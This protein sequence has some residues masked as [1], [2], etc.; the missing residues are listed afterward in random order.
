[1]ARYDSAE[2]GRQPKCLEGTRVSAQD[3]ILSWVKD[4]S[5]SHIFWLTG[6]AGT[7]KSTLARTLLETFL[8]KKQLAAGYFFK[9]GHQG[10]NGTAQFFSTLA[11]QLVEVLPEYKERLRKSLNDTTSEALK[12]KSLRRQ[13]EILFLEP[14]KELQPEES[15]RFSRVIIVDALDECDVQEDICEILQLFSELQ[16]IELFRLC[17]LLTSRGARLIDDAFRTL[18]DEQIPY[19]GLRLHE[20]HAEETKADISAYLHKRFLGMT[21]TS[22]MDRREWPAPAQM[23]RLLKLATFPSPLFIYAS[24]LCRFVEDRGRGRTPRTQLN[25]WL[26]RSDR[27]ISQLGSMYL[28][29]LEEVFQL[30]PEEECDFTSGALLQGHTILSAVILLASPISTLALANLLEMPADSV[31]SW[32]QDLQAVLNTSP[33][34]ERPLELLH[35][36]FGDFLLDSENPTAGK[37]RVDSAETHSMLLS[38]CIRRMTHNGL[39]RDICDLQQ[40]G[41]YAADVEED[42]I[43]ESIPHDLEYASLYWVE[44]FDQSSSI[45][46][47]AADVYSFLREHLLHWLEALSLLRKTV[48]AISCIRR[49]LNRFQVRR[50]KRGQ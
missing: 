33:D 13:F 15:A 7:G 11:S 1:M 37:F 22:R 25:F 20:Q 12:A 23:D 2:V 49:L 9:R 27:G 19:E 36:S 41:V 40:P 43:T 42:L 3:K 6:P 8:G 48:H 30:G 10:R 18:R 24:T 47:T 46:D 26:S 5:A 16:A 34:L 44:H 14:L 4:D 32:I 17:V 35:K 38:K 39:R 31:D 28:P 29:I 21:K 50:S 45:V